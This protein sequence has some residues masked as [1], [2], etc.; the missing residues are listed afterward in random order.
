MALNRR[1]FNIH[2]DNIVECVRA[3][4]Y[5]VAG[6]D[7]LVEEINGPT[8]SVTCPVYT[9]RLADRE[10]CFQFLPGYGEQRWNQDVLGFIKRSGGRLREPLTHRHDEGKWRRAA[11]GCN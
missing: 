4:D 1:R 2:G 3:F 11:G 9:V 8:I 5:I 6:L 7:E 10:L